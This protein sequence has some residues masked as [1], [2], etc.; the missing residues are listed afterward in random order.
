[1]AQLKALAACKL[2]TLFVTL[3]IEYYEVVAS[4]ETFYYFMPVDPDAKN[5]QNLDGRSRRIWK[6]NTR[7]NRIQTIM[8]RSKDLPEPNRAEFL[9]IQLLAIPVPYDEYYLRLEEVKQYREQHEA[10]ESSTED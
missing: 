2:G 7:T 9:K 3:Y 10:E 4:H 8:D 6:F 1:M 5:K